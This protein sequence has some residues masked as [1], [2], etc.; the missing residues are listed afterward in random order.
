MAGR[1]GMDKGK[2]RLKLDKG[3]GHAMYSEVKGDGDKFKKPKKMEAKSG[4]SKHDKSVR[5]SPRE[6]KASMKAEDQKHAI[7][8]F[9]DAK[10]MRRNDNW[11]DEEIDALLNGV[12]SQW[13]MINAEQTGVF[14]SKAR[15]EEKKLDAW[16]AVAQL[17][18]A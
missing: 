16:G 15:T 9:L 1:E 13:S 3:E 8:D 5:K 12:E 2:K 6:K 11:C 18:N 17:V 14:G 4:S 7:E 10:K